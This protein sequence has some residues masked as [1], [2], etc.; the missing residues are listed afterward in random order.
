MVTAKEA[1]TG[2]KGHY[3]LW[4]N[5][6]DGALTDSRWH[7][8]DCDIELI[9][10]QFNRHLAG[11]A[12]FIPLDWRLIKAMVWTESGGPDN[13]AWRDNPVQIGNPGDPG[14]AALFSRNEGGALVIPPELQGKLTIASARFSPQ[15]NI[16]AGVAYLLMRLA[17]YGFDDVADEH[18]KRTYNV[19]VKSGD[20]LEKIAKANGTTV[21]MLR[22]C[23]H[24]TLALSPGQ[25]LNYQK[26]S[27]CKIIRRWTAASATSIARLYNVGDPA[28][29]KKLTYCLTVMQKN[30]QQEASCA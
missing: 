21:A 4:Q 26:S 30:K 19:L 2:A 11:T 25:S 6:I 28:Y 5:T 27:T 8:Y 1:R 3:E 22:K 13:R 12:G 17:M 10:S 24:G 29:A 23:N 15:M 9:V 7:D 20:N 16:S 18:D 14:L